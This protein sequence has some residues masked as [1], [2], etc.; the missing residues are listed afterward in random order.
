MRHAVH[1]VLTFSICFFL[2]SWSFAG[3]AEFERKTLK[4]LP[5]VLVNVRWPDTF[6]MAVSK[7][8]IQTDVELR[9]RKA[10]VRV[11]NNEEWLATTMNPTLLVSCDTIVSADKFQTIYSLDVAL[12]QKVS[13]VRDP[14]IAE[15]TL[16]ITWSTSSIGLLGQFKLQ[17][18][19]D[20][21]NDQTDQ[22]IN[23]YLAANPK[24]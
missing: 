20:S 13:L 14:A 21:V 2:S 5:G 16:A 24:N 15:S 9:L 4:S 22:F 10:G 18:I 12:E 11:L 8:T 3:D 6:N 23:A 1:A 17:L 19:R 7:K